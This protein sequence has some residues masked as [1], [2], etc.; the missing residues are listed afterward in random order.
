MNSQK[1]STKTT[2]AERYECA[3]QP[4][5]S[6][7]ETLESV[8]K[9]VADGNSFLQNLL[10]RIRSGVQGVRV[11]LHGPQPVDASKDD[12]ETAPGVTGQLDFQRFLLEQID[13]SLNE[14]ESL[15]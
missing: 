10:M 15:L 9:R 11:H 7:G 12:I 1:L 2:I 13:R 5:V 6:K 8:Q 4:R 3:L 14:L